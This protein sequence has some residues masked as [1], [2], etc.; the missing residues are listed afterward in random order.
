MGGNKYMKITTWNIRRLGFVYII[1]KISFKEYKTWLEFVPTSSSAPRP[2]GAAYVPILLSEV[3]QE[4]RLSGNGDRE[5]TVV[6]AGLCDGEGER[7]YTAYTPHFFFASRTNVFSFL[8]V[9]SATKTFW[10]HFCRQNVCPR[11]VQNRSFGDG[12]VDTVSASDFSRRPL[13]IDNEET[14]SQPG[15]QYKDKETN[16]DIGT[17]V[18]DIGTDCE[19]PK[20]VE[21]VK[22]SQTSPDAPAP[23][24]RRSARN[25]KPPTYLGDFVLAMN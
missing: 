13:D 9:V 3:G 17:S 8:V 15:G 6:G 16:V 23:T 2:L 1:Q 18:P 4:Q 20:S 11:N 14:I 22:E 5:A 19:P 12:R 25:R 7:A 21:P 24:L 10:R